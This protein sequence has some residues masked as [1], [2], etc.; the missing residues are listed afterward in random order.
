[1]PVPIRS[2]LGILLLGIVSLSA[3]EPP[4][5]YLYVGV[6]GSD[7]DTHTAGVSLLVFDIG[8]GHQFV[9]RVPIWP[10]DGEPE[11]TRGLALAPSS[12]TTSTGLPG[13]PLL[14]ISTTRRLGAIDLASGKVRWEHSYRGQCCDQL[15]VSPNGRVLYAP[16]FGSP[17]WY[18]I[19]PAGGRL[20]STVHVIGWPR[21]TAFSRDGRLA[22]LSA[23]ES[24]RLSIAD[25]ASNTITREI[26]PFSRYVCPF[27]INRKDT[28]VFAN[29]DGLVGFEVADLQTGLILDRVQ[30]DGYPSQDL[31]KYECPSHGIAFRPDET[32]LWVAD[33][34]GNRLRIFNSTTYPPVEMSS[35]QL[36]RQPRWI[37][38]SLDGGYAYASTGD[39]V[40]AKAKTIVAVLKDEHGTVVESERMVEIDRKSPSPR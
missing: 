6:P 13:G 21:R 28:L 26:G 17:E 29:V 24:N 25:T 15:A 10:S 34:V 22:Y 4:A 5:R 16:A 11:R 31:A 1:M 20:V 18:V 30:V 23:W 3:S 2:L 40:D 36:T 19:D 7:L 8:H 32:E 27:T 12:P 9:K 35:I 37:T 14:Y 39:V 33:G 38:F